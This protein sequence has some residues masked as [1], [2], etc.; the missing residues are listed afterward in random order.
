MQMRSPEETKRQTECS[1]SSYLF[2]AKQTETSI[3]PLHAFTST[4]PY[5]MYLTLA[6][7][8][9]NRS[10]PVKDPGVLN[11]LDMVTGEAW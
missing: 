3:S 8:V 9:N 7:L 10:L 6:G 4:I 1:R 11:G 2:S 5:S